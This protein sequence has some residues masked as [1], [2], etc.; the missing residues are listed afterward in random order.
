M[1]KYVLDASALLALINK[2]TGHELVAKVVSLSVMSTVNVT[3]VATVLHKHGIKI[4]TTKRLI[5][6]IL[7][8]ILV[9]DE[10][11]AFTAAELNPL[12]SKFGL[13]LGDR[14]CLSL[15]KH[16]KLP[17]LSADKVWSKLKIDADIK[18][19]R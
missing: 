11:Q 6:D 13:S 9:F 5:A 15:A 16:L 14:A 2:E 3:E 4:E 12:T 19:I 10:A 7:A 8:E 18:I 17:I 1:S